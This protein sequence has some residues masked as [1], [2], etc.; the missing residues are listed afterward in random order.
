MIYDLINN[1]THACLLIIFYFNYR[2]TIHQ[3][4]TQC[5]TNESIKLKLLYCTCIHNNSNPSYNKLLRYLLRIESA[6]N[7]TTNSLTINSHSSVDTMNT[8][9]ESLLCKCDLLVVI[10]LLLHIISLVFIVARMDFSCPLEI[11]FDSLMYVQYINI[12]LYLYF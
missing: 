6:I 4:C 7:S 11:S 3:M 5:D 9:N 12:S 10:L 8:C 1:C 2:F